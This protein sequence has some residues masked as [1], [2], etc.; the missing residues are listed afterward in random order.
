MGVATCPFMTNLPRL[1]ERSFTFIRQANLW[2]PVVCGLIDQ[3]NPG[4]KSKRAIRE[5]KED[6]ELYCGEIVKVSLFGLVGA[7]GEA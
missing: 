6:R 4:F 3:R 2:F 5:W 7:M 1:T